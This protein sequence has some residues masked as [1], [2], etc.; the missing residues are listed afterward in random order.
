MSSTHI[1]QTKFFVYLIISDDT[2]SESRKYRA[3]GLSCSGHWIM[4]FSCPLC[5][6]IVV[7]SSNSTKYAEISHQT[8]ER[9]RKHR[10]REPGKQPLPPT[11]TRVPRPLRLQRP[12]APNLFSAMYRHMGPTRAIGIW[13]LHF[14]TQ[15]SCANNSSLKYSFKFHISTISLLHVCLMVFVLLSVSRSAGLGSVGYVSLSSLLQAIL[16]HSLQLHLIYSHGYLQP[17]I[18]ITSSFD[19]VVITFH[20]SIIP[21]IYGP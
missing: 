21:Q 11:T 4:I 17:P 5:L 2:K 15:G 10:I 7:S 8:S 3:P 18:H 14:S 20:T 16:S 12:M 19:F 1:P 13:E 9:L 6:L